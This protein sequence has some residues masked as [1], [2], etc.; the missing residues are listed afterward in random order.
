[1]TEIAGIVAVMPRNLPDFPGV[2]TP[3]PSIADTLVRCQCCGQ[4]GWVA[5]CQLAV[6]RGN[7]ETVSA[8]CFWCIGLSGLVKRAKKVVLTTPDCDAAKAP[9]RLP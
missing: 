1:M 6:L 4:L 3:R 9:R 8:L 7:P 5:P 2:E